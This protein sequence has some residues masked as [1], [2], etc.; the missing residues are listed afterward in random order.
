MCLVETKLAAKHQLQFKG[1][2]IIRTNRGNAIL[3]GGT[4]ILIR[5]TIAYSEINVTN[6]DRNILESSAIKTKISTSNSL[7]IISAYSPRSK[8]TELATE[9]KKIFTQVDLHK[10]QNYYILTGDLNAKHKLW[11]NIEN[12]SA[13]VALGEWIARY[14]F[15]L[16]SNTNIP[17]SRLNTRYDMIADQRLQVWNHK[18]RQTNYL[19]TFPYDSDHWTIGAIMGHNRC[20]LQELHQEQNRQ[21]DLNRTDWTKF[22]KDLTSN[23]SP[24]VPEDANLTKPEIDRYIELV[25][26]AIN[27]ALKK[28][29]PNSLQ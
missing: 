4:A 9:M 16:H 14:E 27:A 17:T 20:K 3:G 2:N 12:N 18:N 25:N 24:K 19:L 6:I 26:T 22:R 21:S 23:K 11:G 7:Y 1:Y 8:S 13:G 10:K 29:P 15:V 28:I 5:K